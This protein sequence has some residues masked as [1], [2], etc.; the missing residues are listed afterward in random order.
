MAAMI[1]SGGRAVDR[2]AADHRGRRLLAAPDAR[3]AD[4][5]HVGP[6]GARERGVQRLAPAIWHDSVS[7]TRTVIGGGGV[8][9]SF[10]T[11]K[12]W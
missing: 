1:A 6:A 7:H 2:I 12:W 8:S 3:R 9:P 10:T 4:D 5:A 11:S